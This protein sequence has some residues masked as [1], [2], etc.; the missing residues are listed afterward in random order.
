LAH[1][2]GA[3]LLGEHEKIK[4]MKIPKNLLLQSRHL[5]QFYS[6]MSRDGGAGIARFRFLE[7]Y[8]SYLRLKF[9]KNTAHHLKS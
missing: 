9:T 5:P 4:A 8:T 1:H 2:Q 6:G 3:G 7:T